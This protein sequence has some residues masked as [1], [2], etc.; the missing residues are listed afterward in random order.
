VEDN[1]GDIEYYRNRYGYDEK[2]A[3]AR[4]HLK[5]ARKLISEMNRADAEAR[6]AAEAA[7]QAEADAEAQAKL[8]AAIEA[9]DEGA[10]E[11]VIKELLG[12]AR[13]PMTHAAI[14]ELSSNL[15]M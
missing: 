14:F 2:E 1:R 11:D 7:A 10:V 4:Y 12:T 15:A 6:A 5:R 9:G 8:A 13:Y 3:E